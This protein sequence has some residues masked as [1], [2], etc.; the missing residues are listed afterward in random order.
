MKP[1]L[2][3]IRFGLILG[4]LA[5]CAAQPGRSPA[6]S[7]AVW[8]PPPDEPRIRYVASYAFPADIGQS[9]S[10]FN[11][12]GHWL[13][14]ENGESLALHKPCGVAVDENGN[15]VV[16]D[17]GAK[18]VCRL[19]FKNRKWRR[20][21]SAGKVSFQMPVGVAFH[22]G[23]F[24]VADSGLGRVLAFTGDGRLTCEIT[25]GL[26]R[27]A[28]LTVAGER[29]AVV[30]SQAH[31]VMVYDLAGKFIFSFGHRGTG[32]GEFNFP[33]HITVDREGRWWVTDSMNC[34]V[35]S[36]SPDGKYLSQ[37]GG[38]SDTPGHFARPKGVAADASGHIY[39]AD[40]LFDN[41]QIFDPAGHLLLAVGSAG[42]GDPGK[43]DLPAGLVIRS[44]NHIFV[45]DSM[46]RRIQEFLYLGTP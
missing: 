31:A 36:F 18:T 45:A 38:N 1:A 34:R 16:T 7:A 24:Y 3:I 25:N 23:T 14:G 15:L 44:D 9:I 21:T 11:R 35:Q 43:F 19:D 37:F 29:L 5:G 20:Y 4:L 28:G 8:P 39:V 17:T 27:P 2:L 42:G 40:A 6:P 46:N 12:L 26:I 10:V 30:D 41:F 22:Q 32:D 33:T 13:T